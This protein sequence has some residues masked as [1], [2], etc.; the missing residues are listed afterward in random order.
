[1]IG[2]MIDYSKIEEILL[3]GLGIERRP[4][5]IAFLDAPPEGMEKFSGSVPSSCSFWKLAAEGRTFYTVTSDHWNCPIGSYTHNSPLPPEREPE[6][7]QTLSLMGDLGYVRM[8]EIP[9]VFRLPQ[10]PAVVAYGP[11]GDIPVQPSVVLFA[12]RPGRI[13]RLA[14]AAL[15]AGV[16][17]NLPLL[18]RP[19]CMA[20]PAALANGTVASAGCIGNRTYTDIG[21]DELYM[22]TPGSSIEQLAAEVATIANANEKL[23]DYHEQRRQT[24]TRIA[25]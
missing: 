12:G 14:E 18:A 19:T 3:K 1:M 2:T 22:V 7:M 25:S 24:L 21:E 11:L 16:M 5:A 17:S 8:E 15:R 20:L 6:L 23:A 13:M 9:G 4:V 10:T